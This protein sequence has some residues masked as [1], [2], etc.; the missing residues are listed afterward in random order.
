[1]RY[2]WLDSERPVVYCRRNTTVLGNTG[3][4]VVLPRPGPPACGPQLRGANRCWLVSAGPQILRCIGAKSLQH[5]SKLPDPSLTTSACFVLDSSEYAVPCD[6]TEEPGSH[7]RG[8][9]VG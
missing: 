9:A 5:A 7:A 8:K 1:M 6:C 3:R 2:R 4:L